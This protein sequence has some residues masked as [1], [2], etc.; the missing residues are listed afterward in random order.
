VTR[1]A[2]VKRARELY[3]KLAIVSAASADDAR[4]QAGFPE[5]WNWRT[6]TADGRFGLAIAGRFGLLEV[7]P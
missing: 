6:P 1:E 3:E 5:V 4:D 7:P 2:R